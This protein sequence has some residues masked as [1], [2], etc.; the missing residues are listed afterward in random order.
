MVLSIAV[1]S[2]AILLVV[3]F[4]PRHS[5]MGFDALDMFCVAVF[6]HLRRW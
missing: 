5:V 3:I 4:V 1:R 2:K 6:F